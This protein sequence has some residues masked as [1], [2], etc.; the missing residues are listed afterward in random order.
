VDS[1]DHLDQ[2]VSRETL[3][4]KATLVALDLL[5]LLDLQDLLVQLDLLGRWGAQ[6]SRDHEVVMGLSVH[7]VTGEIQELQARLVRTVL[8]GLRVTLAHLEQ[9]DGLVLL[10]NQDSQDQPDPLDLQEL[11]VNRAQLEARV[12]PVHLGLE[13]PLDQQVLCSTLDFVIALSTHARMACL[14]C[15]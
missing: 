12:M 5:D 1:L 2:M 3:D 6:A 9:M 13:D 14:H 15:Y 10:D 11:K 4:L 7:R 8:L